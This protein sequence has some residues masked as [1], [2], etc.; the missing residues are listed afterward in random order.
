MTPDGC[1][2]RGATA[3]QRSRLYWLLAGLL[4]APT[5]SDMRAAL[6]AAADEMTY[7]GDPGPA[8]RE[9]AAALDSVAPA[10]L[11]VEHTRLF[12]GLSPAYGPPPPTES[13]QRGGGVDTML[14]VGAA[15]RDAGY[16]DIDPALPD[17]HLAVEL[18]FMA[19]LA[20]REHEAAQ[21]GDE[22]GV[23]DARML[24][25][26][27]LETHLG[28]WLPDYAQLIEREA[29]GPAFA[30]AIRML[31]RVVARDRAS[32]VAANA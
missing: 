4:R 2:L 5:D 17:D 29:R 3:A 6:H 25:R 23:R 32:L 14:A 20:L 9:L 15:Y 27:F 24:Q 26:H 18:K 8:L 31:D 12:G 30:A 28:A 11:A 19:L 22:P 16:A 21:S 1:A 7:D 13:A 10:T